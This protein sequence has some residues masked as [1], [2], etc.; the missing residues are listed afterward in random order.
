MPTL[1]SLNEALM[2]TRRMLELAKKEEWETVRELE[3]RQSALLKNCFQSEMPLDR[4]ASA[5]V[6]QE[7][8]GLHEKIFKVA[9]H[10]G[11][12]AKGELSMMQKGRD[13]S[14]AYL[15]NST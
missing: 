9:S 6:V 3:Q 14:R 4:S 8:L 15:S 2:L 12:H 7:I 10:F 11:N 1:D 13:A 5:E